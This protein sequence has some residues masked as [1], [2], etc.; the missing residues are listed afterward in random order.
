MQ[1]HYTPPADVAACPHCAAEVPTG[2][3]AHPDLRVAAFA[4]RCL[5]CEFLAPPPLAEASGGGSIV[6]AAIPARGRIGGG[7]AS[8]GRGA[9]HTRLPGP[10]LCAVRPR[11]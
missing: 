9:A 11:W 8:R 10:P 2:G 1:D 6:V 5:A 7:C 3:A 4:W